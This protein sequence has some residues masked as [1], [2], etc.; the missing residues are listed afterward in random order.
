[1]QAI[2]HRAKDVGAIDE[3]QY[4]NFRKQ[5][6]AQKMLA[7][8]PLDDVLSIEQSKLIM[9]AWTM[10]AES[11]DLRRLAETTLGLGPDLV[12]EVCGVSLAPPPPP[13]EPVLRR[14]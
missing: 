4:I 10:I 8:E 11:D 6:S 14:A 3:Y 7:V 9:K 2:A 1:M 12:E 5:I 13:P